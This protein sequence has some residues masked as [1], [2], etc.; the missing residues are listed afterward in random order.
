[1]R[2]FL[3]AGSVGRGYCAYGLL[4]FLLDGFGGV[5]RHTIDLRVFRQHHR[6]QRTDGKTD[7][8]RGK[9]SFYLHRLISLRG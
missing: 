8:H 6:A 2:V 5:V 9:K 1:M 4:R 3:F 7:A